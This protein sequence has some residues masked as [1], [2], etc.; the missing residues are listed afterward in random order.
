[1]TT[2]EGREN[3]LSGW[4]ASGIADAVRLGTKNLP[5]PDA[6]NEI[7]PILDLTS[8]DDNVDALF[9]LSEGEIRIGVG[10]TYESDSDD[11][12]DEEYGSDGRND[13]PPLRDFNDEEDL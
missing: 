4:R 8:N 1:M 2:A 3:I 11:E 13:F 9:S 10:D 5:S 6:F 12:V 7:D